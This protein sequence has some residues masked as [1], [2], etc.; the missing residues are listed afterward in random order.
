MSFRKRFIQEWK[1]SAIHRRGIDALREARLPRH[2]LLR[3]PEAGRALF[4]DDRRRARRFRA[5]QGVGDADCGLRVELFLDFLELFQLMW[6]MPAKFPFSRR[7]A[8]DQAGA[9]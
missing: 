8:S 3:R 7:K 6:P 2:G 1:H 5:E 4:G 9:R